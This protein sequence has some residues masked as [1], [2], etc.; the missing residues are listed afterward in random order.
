M[1]FSRLD[2][3]LVAR[4]ASALLL[5]S[6]VACAGSVDSR[7]YV[8]VVSISNLSEDQA[9]ATEPILGKLA[10][11]LAAE[12]GTHLGRV[13]FIRDDYFHRASACRVARVRNVIWLQPNILSRSSD[14]SNF[15]AIRT[16]VFRCAP[17]GDQNLHDFLATSKP[18]GRHDSGVSSD[19]L[20]RG[21]S[22]AAAEAEHGM[23]RALRGLPPFSHLNDKSAQHSPRR[24]G[25][26]VTSA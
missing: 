21:F 4:G 3:A 2:L 12:L 11:S 9:T 26:N 16:V 5:L 17:A 18:H 24:H 8:A 10:E 6:I 15:E 23:A 20:R 22:D 25:G 14:G 13:V 7:N 1:V 19:G